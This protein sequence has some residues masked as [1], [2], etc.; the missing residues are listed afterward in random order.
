MNSWPA[1]SQ[2]KREKNGKGKRTETERNY[3]KSGKET[4]GAS[5]RA[6][7]QN[8]VYTRRTR[9]D[10]VNDLLLVIVDI[11]LFF[12]HSGLPCA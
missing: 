10:V 9:S 2:R 6:D 11:V 4:S 3:E 12:R 8:A 7:R 5:A 1:G